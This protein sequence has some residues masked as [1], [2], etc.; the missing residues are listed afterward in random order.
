[1][2][3]FAGAIGETVVDEPRLKDRSNNVMHGVMHNAVA[4]RS[5]RNHARLGIMHLNFQIAAGLVCPRKQLALKPQQFAFKPS[6][7]CRRAGLAP[8]A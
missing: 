4:E 8:F 3:A 6:L 5:R 1:M 2:R 7:K